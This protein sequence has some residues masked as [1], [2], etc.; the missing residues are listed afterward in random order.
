MDIVLT[1]SASSNTIG[2]IIVEIYE[3]ENDGNYKRVARNSTSVSS[4]TPETILSF[5]T[6][7]DVEYLIVVVDE[8]DADG[9]VEYTIEVECLLEELR[10]GDKVINST[11]ALGEISESYD[12]LPSCGTGS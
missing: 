2:L 8:S 12:D 6:E 4:S 9:A 11:S 1:A 7:D 10:C 5:P 3:K